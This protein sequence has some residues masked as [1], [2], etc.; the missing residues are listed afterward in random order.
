[1]YLHLAA[2][3]LRSQHN[4]RAWAL[5]LGQ[6]IDQV[7]RTHELLVLEFRTDRYL[8]LILHAVLTG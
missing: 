1:M 5:F 8:L 6:L 2:T 4:S 3:S 7:A